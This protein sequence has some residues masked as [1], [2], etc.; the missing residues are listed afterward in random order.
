[1]GAALLLSL[2]LAALPALAHASSRAEDGLP[3]GSIAFSRDGDVWAWSAGSTRKLFDGEAATDPRWSPDGTAVLYVMVGDSFSDL[4]LHSLTDGSDTLLTANMPGF[5]P[6]TREYVDSSVWV[7]DPSWASSGIIAYASEE[8]TPGGRMVM[9]L[10]AEPAAAPVQV[11]GA[12]DG[13]GIEGISLSADG[14]WT[15]YTERGLD[16]ESGPTRVMVGDLT[17]GS[18]TLLADDDGGVFDP[19]ISPDAEHVVVSIRAAGG[20]TDLWLIDRQSGDRQQVTQ[21]AQAIG[22]TWSPDG[23]WLAYLTPDGDRFALWA[24]E[25]TP[26]AEP[27]SPQR[28]GTFDGIDASGGLSWTLATVP[29]AG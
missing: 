13:G 12:T 8:A 14:R 11:P 18:T 19:T 17:D 29:G 2:S 7:Q 23:R 5:E 10:L 6:G 26:P 20:V 9:W 16:P 15:A 25:I 22:A 27:G 4:V 28:L 1:M 3:E 21:G 24:L